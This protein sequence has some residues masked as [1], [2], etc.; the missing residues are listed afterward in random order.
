LNFQKKPVPIHFDG[1]DS[2]TKWRTSRGGEQSRYNCRLTKSG[3]PID[4]FW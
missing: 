3:R 2:T 1:A 4:A